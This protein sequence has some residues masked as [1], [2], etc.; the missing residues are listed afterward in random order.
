MEMYY[1]RFPS[2]LQHHQGVGFSYEFLAP[3]GVWN[4]VPKIVKVPRLC[5]VLGKANCGI[6]FMNV[7]MSVWS[8]DQFRIAVFKAV[9]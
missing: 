9:S 5:Q 2:L 3:R 4:A 8:G 7:C 6:N 1:N